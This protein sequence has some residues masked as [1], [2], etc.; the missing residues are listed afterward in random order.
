MILN[1]RCDAVSAVICSP[2]HSHLSSAAAS[3]GLLHTNSHH[4][5]LEPRSAQ[6]NVFGFFFFILIY[7][8]VP[9]VLIKCCFL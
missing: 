4:C 8:F 3:A 2:C 1:N 6:I 9:N 7:R 5:D